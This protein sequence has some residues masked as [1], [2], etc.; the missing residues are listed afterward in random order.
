MSILESASKIVLLMTALTVCVGFL[1]GKLPVEFFIPIV[2]GV[3]GFYFAYKG[4]S[5]LP[6]AGK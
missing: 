6:M 3:F 5:N 2:T 1:M 4:D